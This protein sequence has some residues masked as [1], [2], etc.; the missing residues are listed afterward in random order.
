MLSFNGALSCQLLFLR[1][2]QPATAPCTQ[3][4]IGD[5][6]HQNHTRHIKDHYTRIARRRFAQHQKIILLRYTTNEE[7]IQLIHL[8]GAA[9]PKHDKAITHHPIS[10]EL[11]PESEFSGSRQAVRLVPDTNNDATPSD[12]INPDKARA[13]LV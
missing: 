3:S 13:T 9:N 5:Q 1:R 10:T 7:L 12:R 6:V 2:P 4:S 8:C 11:E